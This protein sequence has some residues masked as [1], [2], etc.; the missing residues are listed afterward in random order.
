MLPASKYRRIPGLGSTSRTAAVSVPLGTPPSRYLKGYS[1]NPGT[2][3]ILGS[4]SLLL[5]PYGDPSQGSHPKSNQQQVVPVLSC[6]AVVP[7]KILSNPLNFIRR[8]S[9]TKLNI[10]IN[11][12]QTWIS[13]QTQNYFSNKP[14]NLKGD[15]FSWKSILHFFLQNF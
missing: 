2:A 14:R 7:Y 1:S 13:Q 6:T 4:V 9:F 3:L 11:H 8:S 12:L 5:C 10:E 15:N